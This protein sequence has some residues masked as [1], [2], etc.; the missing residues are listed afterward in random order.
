MYFPK[1]ASAKLSVL[2]FSLFRVGKR[3]LQK[4]LKSVSYLWITVWMLNVKCQTKNETTE[5]YSLCISEKKLFTS[6]SIDS[7]WTYITN[8]SGC[9][10]N[11]TDI[12]IVKCFHRFMDHEVVSIEKVQ[13]E[14]ENV[15]S[16]RKCE[17]IFF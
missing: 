9:L 1:K 12:E 5:L 14:R 7:I 15:W 13:G 4:A 16:Q 10:L 2:S 6:M 17:K 11:Q 8:L 3:N